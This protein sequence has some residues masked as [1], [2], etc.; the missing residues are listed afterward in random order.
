MKWNNEH[1]KTMKTNK[2]SD[3]NDNRWIDDVNFTNVSEMSG[4]IGGKY[5]DDS[6]QCLL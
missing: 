2:E 1:A 3:D 5:P 4:G 6:K